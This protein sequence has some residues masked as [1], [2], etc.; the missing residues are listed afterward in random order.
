[1]N[2]ECDGTGARNCTVAVQNYGCI[3]DCASGRSRVLSELSCFGKKKVFSTDVL[4][5][6]NV[7]PEFR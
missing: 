2:L 5:S 7:L 1:M 6:G 3:V 4:G